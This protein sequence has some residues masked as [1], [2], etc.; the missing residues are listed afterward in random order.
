M[1]WSQ[2]SKVSFFIYWLLEAE[3]HICTHTHSYHSVSA[4]LHQL[5]TNNMLKKHKE[6]GM[7]V[8]YNYTKH[9]LYY[10]HFLSLVHPANEH[11]KAC[12][13]SKQTCAI[14]QWECWRASRYEE[15]RKTTEEDMQSIGVDDRVKDPMWWLLKGVL[16]PFVSQQKNVKLFDYI[17]SRWLSA[18]TSCK[19]NSHYAFRQSGLSPASK[20]QLISWMVSLSVTD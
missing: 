4:Q 11:F 2:F 17:S 14:K 6:R 18:L 1:P 10:C 19:C 12:S 20:C 3:I 7:I 9:P 13:I 15:K 5:C 8:M 16:L